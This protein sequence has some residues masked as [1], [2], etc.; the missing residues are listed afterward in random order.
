MGCLFTSK[1][2]RRSFTD[3]EWLPEFDAVALGINDPGET[4]EVVVIAVRVDGDA[5]GSELGEEGVEV[6]DSI[7]DH[8]GLG[9]AFVARAEVGG[10]F[11]EERP[12]GHAGGCGDLI[13]PEE[14]G[15]AVV[16]EGDA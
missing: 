1:L 8:G 4:A 5:V 9:S 16:A 10:V 3:D 7:V 12:C 14:G 11:G 2:K 6:I 13:G 15:S